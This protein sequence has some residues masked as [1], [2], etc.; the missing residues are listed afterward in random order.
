MEEGGK[1]GKDEWPG[2]PSG[3]G[4]ERGRE[5]EERIWTKGVGG[6][7]VARKKGGRRSRRKRR[8]KGHRRQRRSGIQAATAAAA[9]ASPLLIITAWR[10]SERASACQ[11]SIIA[12]NGLAANNIRRHRQLFAVF[13]ASLLCL[14]SPR[15]S[16]LS[17]ARTSSS[18]SVFS[19]TSTRSPNQPANSTTSFDFCST[20]QFPSPF[21]PDD[22]TTVSPSP[23]FF[24]PFLPLCFRKRIGTIKLERVYR[25]RI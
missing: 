23:L 9:E 24:F 5:R 8:E 19:C 11:A 4:S 15:S 21:P 20:R 18:P 12:T 1:S 6:E 3:G 14:S 16:P 17:L 25:I 10:A 22:G 2:I 7:G 13:L